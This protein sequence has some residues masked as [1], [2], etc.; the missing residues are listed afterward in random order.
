MNDLDF[1]LCVVFQSLVM[2][3]VTYFGMKVIKTEVLG[4]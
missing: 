3:S 1:S 4:I 2:K